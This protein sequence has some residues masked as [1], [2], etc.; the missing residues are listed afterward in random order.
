VS[1]ARTP[2]VEAA[3]AAASDEFGLAEYY[4]DCVRPILGTAR[5]TWP[6]CCGGNCEPCAE[7]L[8]AVAGRVHE[9]LRLSVGEADNGGPSEAGGVG[10]GSAE[11]T[12]G[13]GEGASAGTGERIED[14]ATGRPSV[15]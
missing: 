8:C 5:G 6:R 2:E 1:L 4:R 13:T 3:L 9:R 7:T 11:G 10:V 15:R 14:A 12:E